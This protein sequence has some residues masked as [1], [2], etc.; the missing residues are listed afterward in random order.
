MLEQINR[1]P[2]IRTSTP[3]LQGPVPVTRIYLNT[4]QT[5]VSK[6]YK[7]QRPSRLSLRCLGVGSG[8]MVLLHP[9]WKQLCLLSK[10]PDITHP[11]IADHTCKP[12]VW[13]VDTKKPH[14][15]K[16]NCEKS[17][18]CTPW[19]GDISFDCCVE[20][21]ELMSMADR[22]AES[23]RGKQELAELLPQIERIPI[24]GHVSWRMALSSC[25]AS[26]YWRSSFRKSRQLR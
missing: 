22:C 19:F 23:W 25:W 9:T 7:H 15:F 2:R 10:H 11:Q 8:H 4:E 18:D 3:R 5:D 20:S 16:G 26:P 12:K 24:T 21:N 17:T 13:L 1:W 14:K 6:E